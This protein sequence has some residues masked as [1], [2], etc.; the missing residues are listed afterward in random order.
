MEKFARDAVADKR[1]QC[2]E[3]IVVSTRTL[4]LPVPASRAASVY[5]EIARERERERES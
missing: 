3:D 1:I 5:G 4:D 2:K